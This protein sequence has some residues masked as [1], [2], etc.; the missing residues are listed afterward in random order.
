MSFG[1]G[2][3]F[4]LIHTH[5]VINRKLLGYLYMAQLGQLL[6]VDMLGKTGAPSRIIFAFGGTQTCASLHK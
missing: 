3:H 5:Q 2:S 1:Q 6:A 4:Q